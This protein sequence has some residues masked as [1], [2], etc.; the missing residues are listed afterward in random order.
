MRYEVPRNG[1]DLTEAPF[2]WPDGFKHEVV[3]K[4][5]DLDWRRYPALDQSE[6][7]IKVAAFFGIDPDSLL[8]TR[9]ADEALRLSF[10]HI[11][12]E[13]FSS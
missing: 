8:L 9:G 5:I 13:A 10:Q 1:V 3:G 2:E 4:L 6:V 12:R 11:K 7:K